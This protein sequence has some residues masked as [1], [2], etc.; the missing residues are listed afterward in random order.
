MTDT[1]S[2]AMSLTIPAL[3]TIRTLARAGALAFALSTHGHAAPAPTMPAPIDPGELKI[4]AGF[5]TN[6]LLSMAH[7]NGSFVYRINID[8]TITV[9]PRYNWLRHAGTLYALAAYYELT[10]RPEIVPIIEK[11]VDYMRSRSMASVDGVPGALAI[12]S[13][14]R[15]TGSSDPLTAKLGGS[16]LGLVALTALYGIKPSSARTDEMDGLARFIMSMQ[17]PDGAFYSKFIPSMGGRQDDWVSLYYPG[18]AALG[19]AKLYDIGSNA[20]WLEGARKTLRYLSESRRDQSQVPADHWALIATGQLWPYVDGNDRAVFKRHA[21]QVVES[22]LSQQ[23]WSDNPAINGGFTHDGKTTPTATRLEGLLAVEP[24]F[25]D[26]L[27]L[28]RRLTIGASWGVRFLLNAQIKTGQ[29]KG[30]FTRASVR[31]VSSHP[32]A[33]AINERATEVRIDY[34]QHAL[35]AFI[36]YLRFQESIR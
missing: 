19:L 34:I 10:E 15:V 24:L 22:M 32:N 1:S 23:V 33:K 9:T 27:D 3:D 29:Y 6:F 7:D 14:G 30:A 4:A 16:G 2:H 5:A 36:Q 11:A 35:S 31:I 8:P 21:R 17:L 13:D 28:H 18:E 25:R 12:W 20:D 26:Q